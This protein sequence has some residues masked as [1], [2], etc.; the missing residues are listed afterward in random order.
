MPEPR[1]TYL[2]PIYA[3]AS[4]IAFFFWEESGKHLLPTSAFGAAWALVNCYRNKSMDLGCITMGIVA[5]A[6][7][8]E[9]FTHSTPKARLHKAETIGCVLAAINFSLPIIFWKQIKDPL[10]KRKS[11]VWMTV[12]WYYLAAMT[13]YWLVAAYKNSDRDMDA[14]VDNN[15]DN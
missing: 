8:M 2:M 11:A 15:N 10:S 6:S 3:I 4:W 14:N 13:V 5:V 7:A 12:F 9:Q 1:L